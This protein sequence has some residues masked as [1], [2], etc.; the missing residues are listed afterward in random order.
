MMDSEQTKKK[1]RE[2]E[3]DVADMDLSGDKESKLIPSDTAKY[4]ATNTFTPNMD[5]SP[6]KTT[7][8]NSDSPKNTTR[9]R[10]HAE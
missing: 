8:S 10:L 7:R 4:L 6:I 3:A 1:E 2:I 5:L 9:Q